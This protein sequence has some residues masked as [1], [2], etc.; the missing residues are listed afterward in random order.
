MFHNSSLYQGVTSSQLP[1]H[2]ADLFILLRLVI[3][4][5]YLSQMKVFPSS[6]LSQERGPFLQKKSASKFNLF[7]LFIGT[8]G[9][10]YGMRS[11]FQECVDKYGDLPAVHYK[12][13]MDVCYNFVY[14]LNIDCHCD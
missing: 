9:S 11:M 5:G 14:M 1:T 3:S 4:T 13:E 6:L 12:H 10:P 7:V 2:S 8:E